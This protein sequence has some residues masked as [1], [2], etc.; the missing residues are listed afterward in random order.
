M[1]SQVSSFCVGMLYRHFGN[2]FF[3]LTTITTPHVHSSA[4]RHTPDP[5]YF[6]IRPTNMRHTLQKR[7]LIPLP[8][9]TTS[10]LSYVSHN[11]CRMKITHFLHP[12]SR[13]DVT[14]PRRKLAC[15]GRF[16]RV[17][18]QYTCKA[19]LPTVVILKF[20]SETRSSI[21]KIDFGVLFCMLS[22][23]Y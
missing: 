4:R 13:L 22:F 12:I 3:F 14:G 18:N 2:M 6:E 1:N 23:R 10:K 19:P 11:S 8:E 21:V 7:S 15:T 20:K 5:S 9:T 16:N 17:F